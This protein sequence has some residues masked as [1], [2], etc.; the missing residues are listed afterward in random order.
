MKYIL[1]TSL[2]FIVLAS[3]GQTKPDTSHALKPL[4]Y[5]EVYTL[6]Q[7]NQELYNRVHKID[8]SSRYRDSLDMLL[9]ISSQT[10]YRKFPV[11]TVKTKGNGRK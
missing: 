4:T 6:L 1:T 9:N 2:A 11:D 7:I 8:M 10:L 5:R 3:F